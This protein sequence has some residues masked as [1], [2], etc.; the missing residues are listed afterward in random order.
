M[1]HG[2]SYIIPLP[3]YAFSSANI[4]LYHYHQLINSGLITLLICPLKLYLSIMPCPGVTQSGK[5]KRRQY[6][7]A[8]PVIFFICNINLNIIHMIPQTITPDTDAPAM[9]KPI[10]SV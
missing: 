3:K 9:R 6:Q 10:A 7:P 2:L 5:Y 8:E 4:L 1:S